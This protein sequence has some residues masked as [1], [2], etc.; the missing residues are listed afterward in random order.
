MTSGGELAHAKLIQ[1]ICIWLRFIFASGNA[2]IPHLHLFPNFSFD[3][4]VLVAVGSRS[5]WDATRGGVGGIGD[6]GRTRQP[7]H[8][9]IN[10]S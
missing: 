2:L 6:A 1:G 10:V 9:Q 3:I 4:L 5:A 8:D 7:P